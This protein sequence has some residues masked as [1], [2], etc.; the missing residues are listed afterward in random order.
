VEGFPCSK[1]IQILDGATFEYYEELSQLGQL[2][3]LNII[4]GINSRTKLN[5]NLL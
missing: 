4:H 3:I 2:L 1:N 5:L